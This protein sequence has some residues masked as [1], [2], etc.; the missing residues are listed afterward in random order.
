MDGPRAQAQR[1]AAG[2]RAARFEV[3]NQVDLNQVLVRA[4]NDE[5]TVTIRQAAQSSF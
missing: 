1:L 4:G 5:A 3:L 2:L